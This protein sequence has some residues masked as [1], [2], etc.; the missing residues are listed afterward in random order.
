MRIAVVVVLDLPCRHTT[1]IIE[2]GSLPKMP[3]MLAME[4]M[5]ATPVAAAEPCAHFAHMNVLYFLMR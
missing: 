4:L 3:P 2:V 5:S 1:T